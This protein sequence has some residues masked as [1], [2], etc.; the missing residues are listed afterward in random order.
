MAK[1]LLV[2]GKEIKVRTSEKTWGWIKK[3]KET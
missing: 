1:K 3:S 2:T